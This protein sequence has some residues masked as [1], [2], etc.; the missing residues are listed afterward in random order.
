MIESLYFDPWKYFGEIEDLS[1][2]SQIHCG[3]RDFNCRIIDGFKK[4]A[5]DYASGTYGKLVKDKRYLI[6]QNEIIPFLRYLENISGGEGKWR[7][8]NFKN[9]DTESGWGFKYL[10]FYRVDDKQ[11]F[12]ENNDNEPVEWRSL[13]EENINKEAIEDGFS[14]I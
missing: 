1:S 10:R 14:K 12:V 5:K 9:I 13:T 6:N 3:T 2:A 11:F 4:E 7:L 8:L